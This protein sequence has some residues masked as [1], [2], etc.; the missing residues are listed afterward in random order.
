[1]EGISTQKFEKSVDQI[2]QIKMDTR[3]TSHPAAVT[4]FISSPVKTVQWLVYSFD[5]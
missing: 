1:M 5:N 4:N 3:C 2:L